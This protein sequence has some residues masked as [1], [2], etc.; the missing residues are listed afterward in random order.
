MSSSPLVQSVLSLSRS[1]R[2]IFKIKKGT[3]RSL[4]FVGNK[5]AAHDRKFGINTVEYNTHTHALNIRRVLGPV[6]Y[7]TA[8]LYF[9]CIFYS[10]V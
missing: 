6:E 5:I 10:M 3:A 2:R 9:G 4:N 7:A 8:F 1:S